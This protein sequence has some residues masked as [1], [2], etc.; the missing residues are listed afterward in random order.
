MEILGLSP[1]VMTI[2]ICV[3]GV[4]FRIF[5]GMQGKSIKEFKINL[6]ITTLV[7]GVIVSIGLVAPVIEV[8]PDNDDE[9]IQLQI[10]AAQLAV[11]IGVDSAVRKG[12]KKITKS[13]D[14]I[15]E[16][17]DDPDDLPPGKDVKSN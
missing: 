10:V 1:V 16:P 8:I 15:P 2:L 3:S 11:V 5:R 17:I 13:D 6:A 7:L 4:S 12:Y 9:L 14:T